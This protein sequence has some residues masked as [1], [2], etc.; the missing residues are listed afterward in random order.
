[1]HTNALRHTMHAMCNAARLLAVA[2][3]RPISNAGQLLN[4]CLPE[5]AFYGSGAGNDCVPVASCGYRRF[6]FVL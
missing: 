5:V 3:Y 1:M 4:D 2:I 6:A